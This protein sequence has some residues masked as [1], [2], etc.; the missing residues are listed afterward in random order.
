M[1]LLALVTILYI[2]PSDFIYYITE[3]LNFFFF[4][5]LSFF[6]VGGLCGFTTGESLQLL[7]ILIFLNCLFAKFPEIFHLFVAD[8]ANTFSL[9]FNHLGLSSGF[10]STFVLSV[11]VISQSRK[12]TF[13]LFHSLSDIS[14]ESHITVEEKDI[15]TTISQFFPS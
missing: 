1:V 2:S 15:Q 9:R 14:E 11:V 4:I 10:Y 8:F 7:V 13:Y 5:S 12:Y 6:L 3:S